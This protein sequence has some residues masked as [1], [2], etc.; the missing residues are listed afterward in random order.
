MGTTSLQIG[1]IDKPLRT[2][3]WPR[4]REMLTPALKTGNLSWREIVAGL[5]S[6]EMRVVAI[7]KGGDRTDLLA[8]AV[9]R[10]ALTPDGEALE[11]VAAAGSQYRVWAAWGMNALQQAARNADMIGVQ[12]TGRKGWRRVFPQIAAV[13]DIMKVPA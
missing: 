1:Y 10:S 6:D 3:A 2:A 11:I 12:F 8:C 4:L 5:S 13:G 9:V 7:R